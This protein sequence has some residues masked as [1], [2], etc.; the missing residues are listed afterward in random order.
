MGTLHVEGWAPDYGTPLE[1]DDAYAPDEGKV[2]DAVEVSGPWEPMGGHDDGVETVAF[3][4]GVRRIDAR[5]TID[6]PSGPIPGLCGTY[7]VGA[8][9]WRRHHPSAEVTDVHIE[10]LAVFTH[11]RNDPIPV[12]GPQL[13]YRTEAV[14]DFDPALLIRHFHGAMRKAEGLLAE[15]LAQAGT[16]VVSDGPINDLSA[17][18]KVGYIK[19]HRVPYLPPER[20]DIIARLTPGTRTPLFVIGAQSA[21]FPRYSW[22]LRL[23]TLP[24]GHSWTGIVRCE[25]STKLGLEVAQRLADRSAALLPMVASEAHIDPRAPQNLVP[26]AALERALRRRMGDAAYIHRQLRS[27]VMRQGAA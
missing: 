18:E 7:G 24:G 17:T 9:C 2:D 8:L 12:A 16:F 26:I 4:D 14:A 19:T 13:A 1:T 23:A 11:G 20:M 22:Y 5:L 27:A 25:A 15:R 21:Q 3:V 6:D 10:R